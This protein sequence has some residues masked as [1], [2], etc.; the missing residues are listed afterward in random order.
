MTFRL[1]VFA[2]PLRIHLSKNRARTNIFALLFI[3][4]LKNRYLTT[5]KDKDSLSQKA[6]VLW[7]KSHHLVLGTTPHLV[8]KPELSKEFYLGGTNVPE[9]DPVPIII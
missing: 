4:L 5:L 3:I 8:F 9:G 6:D 1:G 7:Q 2:T